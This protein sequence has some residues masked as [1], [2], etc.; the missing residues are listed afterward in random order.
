M[1]L[2]YPITVNHAQTKRE[3]RYHAD[4]DVSL[5]LPFESWQLLWQLH[6]VNI[7]RSGILCS[8][9]LVAQSKTHDPLDV[10]TLLD[11]QPHVHLQINVHSDD[12]FSPSIEAR[13]VRKLRRSHCLELAF[14][15]NQ[16]SSELETLLDSFTQRTDF[17][18]ENPWY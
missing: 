15:F 2:G 8:Y 17:R 1:N 3:E 11:A 4:M 7:S 14:Q 12:L 18:P 9:D 5:I 16:E 6:A 13:L 10:C